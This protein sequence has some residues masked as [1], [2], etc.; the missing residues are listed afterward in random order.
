[1]VRAIV[2]AVAVAVLTPLTAQAATVEIGDRSFDVTSGQV[3]NE[4][5]Q[6]AHSATKNVLWV[7]GTTHQFDLGYPVAAKSA[8]T[9]VDP[10]N[11]QVLQTVT[12]PNLSGP[13]RPEAVYGVAVD[14]ERDRVW[15]S[16]T[17]E[18][19]VVVYDAV[20]GSRIAR[21]DGVGHSRDIAIDPYRDTA[22]V[23]DPNNGRIVKISTDTLQVTGT[24]D[25]SNLN[26]PGFSPM[27]L[28]L[29]ATPTESLLY[30]VNLNNGQVVELDNVAQDRRVIESGG[31][32][33]SGIAV[34]RDRGRIY[35]ASQDSS[36]LRTIDLSTGQLIRTV[37]ASGAVLNAAVDSEQGIVYS[38]VF[39]TNAVLVT[40]ADT[41]VKIGEITLGTSP[42]DVIVA[43]GSAFA[44]DRSVTGP[45]GKS[46]LWK[47][48]PTGAGN[49]PTDPT[50]P[51]PV[52]AAVTVVGE[53]RIGGTVTLRGTGWKHPSNGG[54]TIAVKLDDGAFLEPGGP[55]NGVWQVIQAADDGTFEVPL[56]LPDG[57]T[58][59]AGSVPAYTTGAHSLRFLTGSLKPGDQGRSVKVD[60]TV[61]AAT[62]PVPTDPRPTDPGPTNPGPGNL[63]PTAPVAKA[64]PKVG[65]SVKRTLSSRE[66]V[67]VRAVVNGKKPT[68]TVVVRVGKRTVKVV[69][70]AKRKGN[71]AIVGVRL[72]RL[73][74]GTHT[75]TIVYLGDTANA[76]STSKAVLRVTR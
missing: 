54:S 66:R 30:T 50:D 31:N 74:A 18:D 6:V 60:I 58:G 35:V 37:P 63:T 34:D 47:I 3:Q 17:R 29:H 46:Q 13:T 56:R 75:V 48:T 10:A 65:A 16:A 51:Q 69:K 53:A 23:S 8:L 68:G 7:T 15:T 64:K 25:A 24:L 40:D 45:E 55:A 14:D 62:T 41:G 76:R 70:I 38:A 26:V 27:S 22:Y 19:A 43:G 52:Q 2:G 12:P 42:N 73:K 44:V 20:T 36:D 61:G 49:G 39:G 67:I 9:K 28:D 57:T 21:I 32:R 5:Y 59:A 4:G 71:Q 11:L 72:P 33:A 1:M